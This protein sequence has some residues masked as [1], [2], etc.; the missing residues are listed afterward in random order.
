[1]RKAV[2]LA[3]L[4]AA[5]GGDA[6]EGEAPTNDAPEAEAPV[7]DAAPVVNMIGD[8]EVTF[9]PEL[10]VDIAA[11]EK[12][13]SGLYIRVLEEGAGPVTVPGDTMGV[14]YTLWLPDGNKV[15][16]SYDRDEPLPMVLGETRLVAGWVEGVTGMNLGEKRLLVLPYDL[17]YGE[18]GRPGIPPKAVLV[19]EVELASHTPGMK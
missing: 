11:M 3:V 10:G 9:A 4:V 7:A 12:Q 16:S 14:H 2:F 18:A 8:V 1:M 5:C 6:P 17:A 13:E 19:F 15:D